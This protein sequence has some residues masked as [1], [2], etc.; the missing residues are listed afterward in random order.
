MSIET[1]WVLEPAVVLQKFVGK[2]NL[3]EID[4]ASQALSRFV[5]RSRKLHILGDLSQLQHLPDEL[6]NIG[7]TLN[8]ALG[9]SQVGWFVTYGAHDV[10]LNFA[11]AVMPHFTRLQHKHFHNQEEA[12]DFLSMMDAS[13]P[14]F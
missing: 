5:P 8:N 11:A 2:P 3:N 10:A 1:Q 9:R 13:L 12:F 7:E 14:I 6:H 4:D